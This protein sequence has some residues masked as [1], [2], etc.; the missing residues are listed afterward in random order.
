MADDKRI[1]P[2]SKYGSVRGSDSYSA[3]SSGEGER[4]SGMFSAQIGVKTRYGFYP[5]FRRSGVETFPVG[6]PTLT[7]GSAHIGAGTAITTAPIFYDIRYFT[8]DKFYFPRDEKEANDVWRLVYK[9]DP[10]VGA[11]I[12]L[13]ADFA[14]SEFELL[15]IDDPLIRD[16]YESM[17]DSVQLL[18]KLPDM[19]REFLITGKV[20]PH[21]IFDAK[22]GYWKYL[23]IHN[24]NWLKVV[25]IPFAG[26][27]PL[28]YLTLPD[29]LKRLFSSSDPLIQER[30]VSRIPAN[31]RSLI[32]SSMFI[33]LDNVNVS[34]IARRTLASDFT[35]TSLLERIYRML[36]YEDFLMNAAL[37]VAQRQAV[38]LRLFKLGDHEKD[39]F[40][41]KEDEEALAEML[42]IAEADPLAALIFHTG[43]EVEYIGVSDRFWNISRE[44]DF[45]ENLKLI[46]LGVSKSFLVGESSFASA[47]AGLQTFVQKVAGLRLKFEMEWLYPKFFRP[48][49]IMNEFYKRTHAEISHGIRV[50]EKHRE[51]IIPKIR[52]RRS[53]EPTQDTSILSI[54][55]ELHEKGLV[56]DRTLAAGAGL[57]LDVE[58]QNIREEMEFKKAFEQWKKE[59]GFEEKKEEEG[60]ARFGSVRLNGGY[61]V[62]SRFIHSNI[63][64]EKG[65]Y[66]GFHYS[67]FEP[68]VAFC[69]GDGVSKFRGARNLVDV[70][71]QLISE[72]WSN[73]QL[74]AL[75]EVLQAE[76]L[77]KGKEQILEEY[78]K[79]SQNPYLLSGI[80]EKKDFKEV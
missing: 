27:E 15:G 52:W 70:Y 59:H 74:N 69:R 12:D 1:I 67:L 4:R 60:L 44:W 65:C 39:W 9:R 68:V 80:I 43:I 36:M 2:G 5:G 14:W 34:Y 6:A 26:E 33:P 57:N 35:G 75:S 16:V 55:R 76:G 28:I 38:P 42:A 50:K 20:V 21:L 19:S 22:V 23:V 3:Y 24:P 30:I 66:K 54:W 61:H 10:V 53:L 77:I 29:E 73:E 8:P 25:F 58:R 47:V 62:P 46:G 71:Q 72:G 78:E 64:D 56:S 41:T 17:C 51:L 18:A 31:L 37:A 63:F 79:G 7:F 49:A 32:M 11:A 13:Y 45:I 48:I 40:P